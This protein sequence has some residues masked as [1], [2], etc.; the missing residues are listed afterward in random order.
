MERLKTVPL[1]S[2]TESIWPEPREY[3]YNFLRKIESNPLPK[4]LAVLGCSDGT[5][6]LP[7]ARRGFDVLAIDVDPI[8]LYGGIVSLYG[9]DQEIVGLA[10][11]LEIEGLQEHVTIVHEDFVL[12]SPRTTY[13]GVFTSGSIHYKENLRHPLSD[14]MSSI[15]SFVSNKGYL[16]LE[17]IH[18]SERNN[19]PK[20]YFT[21]NTIVSFFQDSEWSISSKRRKTY[22]ED[23]N[24]RNPEIHTITWGRLHAI[25]T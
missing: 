3:F 5:Y 17:Y 4:T 16:L 23:P 8:A 19:D 13:S 14:I 20:R 22:T 9:E 1:S 24:P 2:K 25:K 7:A 12:Y 21:A 6:V 10:N 11:R 15:K 18:L